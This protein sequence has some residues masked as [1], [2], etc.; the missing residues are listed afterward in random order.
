MPKQLLAEAEHKH[1]LRSVSRHQRK[2][3][4]HPL[5][6]VLAIWLLISKQARRRSVLKE[7]ISVRPASLSVR[8]DVSSRLEASRGYKLA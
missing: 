8:A 6:I 2:P 7:L 3:C 4:P 1:T 5:F